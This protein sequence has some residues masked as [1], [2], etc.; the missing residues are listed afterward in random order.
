MPRQLPAD[1][2]NEIFEYLEE[3]KKTLQSCL[4]VNH[5]Y[6]EI[7]VRILWRNVWNFQYKA[8]ASSS[9]IGTLISCLPKESK[10]L[11][12]KNGI[13]IIDQTQRSPFFNY[14]SFCKVLSIHKIDHM[15]QHNLETQQLINLGSLNY[16]KYLFSQ[17]I[18]KMFMKQ[19]S[20]L[21]SLDYYSDESKNIQNF[22]IIYF[23]GAENCL[24]YLT[25][26]NCSSDIYAEFF[27]QIS[28]I[29]HNIKSITID[30]EDIISDG[31]TE[32]I[33]LQKHLKNLKLLSNNYG[34]TEN[35]TSSLTKSSL[36][37]T[38][39][40]IMQY[41][42]PLSFISIFKNLQEL[43]LS[44]DY[45]DSFYDFN[46]LQYITFSHLR[47]LKFLFAIPRV[48]TLIKF[49]EINGKN[50]TEFH[51]GDHDNS[52]NLAVA[53]F[54]PSLKNLITLFEENELETLKIILNNCQY[55]ESIRV[56]CGEGYLN[57]KE[58]LNVL[59]NYSPKYFNKLGIFY[60][61]FNKT[62]IILSKDLEEFFINWK[63][64]ISQNSLSLT[65]YKN[66]D[67]FGLESNVENMEII[68]KY[69]KLGIIDKFI[70]KEYD[71]F[72]Y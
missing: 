9:I 40:V 70:T 67:G 64:R 23:P 29:C 19:I 4:L 61:I 16:I 49:L 58:F 38:K 71:Y 43:V 48:E 31:L 41:Y 53:K 44:F 20:S 10:E 24:T 56:W 11:L 68:K 25:E 62:S 22:M 1:C 26:L 72:E 30:F 27:Y 14:P 13:L 37:L 59:V 50:L 6:C 34:G 45:R 5:L 52:L 28:Q 69:M 15:I 42:I 17:E 32:L 65:I 55:L 47:V 66:F 51:V 2:L 21:K 3:D 36:T 63:N 33:S 12:Y 54:C 46:M 39:L 57:D 7:A 60:Y 8:R 18:L 35:F